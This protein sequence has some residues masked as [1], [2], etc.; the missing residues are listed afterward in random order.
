MLLFMISLCILLWC[1]SK[2]RKKK[3]I[4]YLNPT[5]H[6][7]IASRTSSVDTNFN[8]RYVGEAANVTIIERDSEVDERI[9]EWA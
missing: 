1:V 7:T 8:P 2:S 5:V 4:K 3:K 6:F 9:C